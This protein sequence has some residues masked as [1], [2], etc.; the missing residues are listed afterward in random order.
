[1]ITKNS[2]GLLQLGREALAYCQCASALISGNKALFV[3][4]DLMGEKNQVI[5][6]FYIRSLYLHLIIPLPHRESVRPF[7]ACLS[8]AT[9]CWMVSREGL[10]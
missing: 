8:S 10:T 3:S 2:H 9:H 6:E 7:E 5:L 1:M 4:V